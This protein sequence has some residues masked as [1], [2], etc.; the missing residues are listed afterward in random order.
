MT[1]LEEIRNEF[2]IR[3]LLEERKDETICDEFHI[4]RTCG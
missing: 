4:D 3:V 2:K 1:I